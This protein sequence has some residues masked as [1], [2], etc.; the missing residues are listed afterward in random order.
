[1]LRRT[2]LLDHKTKCDV[3][4]W[5]TSSISSI[6]TISGTSCTS[7]TSSFTCSDFIWFL[8]L[9]PAGEGLEG[10]KFPCELLTWRSYTRVDVYIQHFSIW[11]QHFTYHVFCNPSANVNNACKT[12]NPPI[13]HVFLGL[14]PCTLTIHFWK[15]IIQVLRWLR[16]RPSDFSSRF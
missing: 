11:I 2:P 12:K 8:A 7:C 15:Q 4:A 14:L 1:M 6:S 9:P 5:G 13:F 10:I 3:V 16:N